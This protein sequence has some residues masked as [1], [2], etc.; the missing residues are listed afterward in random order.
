[1]QTS[2]CLECKAEIGGTNHDPVQGF[3]VMQT[4]RDSTKSGHILGDAQRRDL[5]DMQDTKNMSPAPFALLRLF[6]HMAMLLGAGKKTQSVQQIIIPAVPDPGPFLVAHLLKDMEQLSRALGKGVDDTDSTIHLIIHSL[7]EP[8]PTSQR[9]VPY[10]QTLS[11]KDA[12]NGWENA[13]NNDVITRQLKDL[14]NQ[15]KEVSAFIR[16]DERVSSNP[17]MKLTFGKPELFL[18]CLPKNFLIHNSSIWSCRRKVSMLSLAHIVEQNNGRDTL[19]VLW[20]FLQRDAELRLVRFLPDILVLQRD[21]V[22]KFQN[23]TDLNFKTIGEFLDSHKEASLTW[24]EKYIKIF[25]STW[26]QLR[27]SLATTGEIKLPAEYTQEDLGLKTDLQVLLP[28]RQGL[29]LCSTALVSYLITLHNDLVYTVEKHTGEESGYTVSP[30]DL[31]ELHVIRYESERD[32][33]PLIL[34]NCQYS[35]ECGQ[36]TLMEYDLPKIQHQIITRFLQGKPR[37][38]L[39]GIPTLVNRQDRNYEIIFKDVK[40]KVQQELLQPLTQHNLVKELQSYRDVCEALSTAELALGFL[41]LT[42]GEPHVPLGTYLTEVLKMTDNMAPHIFKALSRCCLRHCVA[43]WQLLSSLKSETMISLKRDPFESF[44][45]EYKHPLQEEH[46]TTLNSFCT[47]SSAGAVL[48]EIHELLLLVLKDPNATDTFRP[49]WGLK[50]TVVSYMERKNLDFP[51]E[52]EELFPE[53]ILLSQC[54]D[55]WKYSVGLRKERNQS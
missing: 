6:T 12:R 54:I 18:R 19:P 27:V 28:Q 39:T 4:Q 20:R 24:Y 8:H 25:L 14:D 35:M 46:K 21:L 44:S 23:M 38:T 42:G 50:D 48:L 17:V 16:K 52:V 45:E 10:D 9:P 30:A 29:G 55:M 26:N 53:E 43:L 41:A 47:K 40:S 22:K 49:D 34:S 5:P 13:M 7:L 51:S 15:L 2:R 1:M 33:L 3:Q 11:T 31:T 32:L 37:I 36:E